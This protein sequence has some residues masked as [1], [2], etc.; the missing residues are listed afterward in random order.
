MKTFSIFEAGSGTRTHNLS[1]VG[2]TGML[3]LG[4]PASGIELFTRGGK[5][6]ERMHTVSARA[7]GHSGLHKAVQH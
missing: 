3:P 5:A 1:N 2:P 4:Y 6:C 7:P